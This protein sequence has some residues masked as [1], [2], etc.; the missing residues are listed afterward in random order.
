MFVSNEVNC[1]KNC[2]DHCKDINNLARN[3]KNFLKTD[4][5]TWCFQYEPETKRQGEGYQ[6][7]EIHR[8]VNLKMK[9]MFNFFFFFR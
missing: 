8:L 1:N 4:D 5:E 7:R 6:M 9:A 3:D 2:T